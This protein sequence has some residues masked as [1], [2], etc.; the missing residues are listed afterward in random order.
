MRCEYR[1]IF[2]EC[3]DC[4][5]KNSPSARN[6]Y[7]CEAELIDP[8]SKLTRNPA[9]AAGTPFQVAVMK[10]TLRQHWKGDSES[11]RVTYEVTDGDKTYEV[12][13]FLKGWGFNKFMRDVGG[14]ANTIELAVQSA[15]TLRM[16]TRL[17][18]KKPKGSKWFEVCTRH[19]DS[20]NQL[21]SKA[22]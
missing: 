9:I 11:L 12:N 16:P 15:S 17:M 21:D 20:Q 5:T 1:F 14:I 22:A 8:N 13:Q 10:M 3:P 4:L 18:I 6:C 7:K 19:F 2:K